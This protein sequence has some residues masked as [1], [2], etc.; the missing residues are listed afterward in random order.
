M[1]VKINIVV[2]APAKG[3]GGGNRK[4]KIYYDNFDKKYFKK[5][6]VFLDKNPEAFKKNKDGTF[7]IGLEKLQLFLDKKKADFFFSGK[8]I[9]EKY[10]KKIKKNCFSI[11]N[12]NFTYLY[13]KD[14]KEINMIISKT[15]YV[16]IKLINKKIQN[17][18]VVY[19]PIDVKKWE[20]LRNNSQGKYKKY[21]K[22]KKIK[23]VV[24]RLARAEPSKWNYLIIK[25]LLQMQ[26]RKIYDYGFVFAGM[27]ALYRKT[28]QLFLGEKMLSNILFLPE[29]KKDKDLS[30]FYRSIDLFW[31]TSLIGESFGNVIAE[32]FCFKVPVITDYKRFVRKN[33]RIDFWRYDAQIELV[34]D[35]KNGKYCNYPQKVI[36]FLK[37]TNSKKLRKMGENGLKKVRSEYD[38]RDTCKTF[39]KICYEYLRKTKN[40]SRDKKF[41]SI[42]KKPS[43]KEVRDFKKEYFKRISYAVNINKIKQSE[44]RAYKIQEWF[45]KKIELLY[46]AVRKV[47]KNLKI[48]L[49]G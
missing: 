11:I 15:D 36:D 1:T 34:D 16:K 31:Q 45:W 27:S 24:G 23:F 5:Y 20:D 9:P 3:I 43:E 38:V 21:F 8:K 14:P 7:N 26:K 25:T 30:N 29:L 28:L 41:E 22:N 19:N 44:K 17:S 49:E 37:N 12:V 4:F 46:V 42:R 32:S 6:Y 48:E 40:I 35:G 18:H 10:Y 39:A 13:S 2:L 33:K 47:C